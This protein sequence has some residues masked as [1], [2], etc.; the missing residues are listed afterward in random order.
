MGNTAQV[1]KS[2]L[3]MDEFSEEA[4][5]QTKSRFN[6]IREDFANTSFLVSDIAEQQRE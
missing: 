5:A 3:F 4:W 2:H 1:A 6:P